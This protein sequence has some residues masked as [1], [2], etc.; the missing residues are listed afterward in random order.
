MPDNNF[1]LWNWNVSKLLF[2]GGVILVIFLVSL[3]QLRIGEMKTRDAQRKADARLVYD[4]LGSFYNDFHY[5]PASTDDGKIIQCKEQGLETCEWGEG[6]IVDAKNVSYLNKIPRDPKTNQGSKYVYEVS[7]DRKSARIYATLEY[8][9]DPEIK[10][11]LT[12]E[13]GLNVQCNWYVGN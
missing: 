1:S 11:H 7:P 8:K 10:N 6:P 3:F 4:A 12:K 13:C 2:T 9:R 5:Y